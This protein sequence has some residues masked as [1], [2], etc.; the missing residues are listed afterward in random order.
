MILISFAKQS[1]FNIRISLQE[2][3]RQPK[4]AL[5]GSRD[6]IP[7]TLLDLNSYQNCM[8]QNKNTWN[9]IQF[10]TPAFKMYWPFLK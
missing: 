1:H 3:Q 8:V 9:N 10:T 4:S 2:C 6:I 7:R 5:S